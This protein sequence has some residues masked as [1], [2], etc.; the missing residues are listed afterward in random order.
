MVEGRLGQ[1]TWSKIS[2]ASK[3]AAMTSHL[4]TVMLPRVVFWMIVLTAIIFPSLYQPILSQL[5]RFLSSNSL[6]RFSG[7]E[8]LETIFCYIVIEPLYTFRFTQN[9]SL[10]I[11]VRHKTVGR[12]GPDNPKWPVMKRPS[13][14]LMEIVTYA[15][16]LLT[17][18]FTLIKKFADVPV[19]DIRQ[20]GG[21]SRHS[22]GRIGGFFLAPTLHNFSLNS[23][24]QLVRALPSEAPSSRRLA[25]ELIAAFFIYDS[26]FFF[27]HIAFHKLPFLRQIHWPHH[28]HAEMNPQVTNKLSITERV[29]LILLANFALNIIRSHVLT[30]TAFVPCFVYLLVE[31]HSGLDLPWAYDKIL[32]S[33]W[34]AG[35]EKH[36][37]HHRVGEG[38]YQPFFSWWDNLLERWETESSNE[39]KIIIN[40]TG[41]TWSSL[42]IVV[43]IFL[44]FD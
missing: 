22:D 42:S 17:L 41:N 35:S 29:S 3:Q 32:P 10:R 1:P 14:R 24:L 43:R 26:L 28:R 16:P 19:E 36:A 9:P 39:P 34:G 5:W 8:T 4:G 11:D 44:G 23:P 33:G 7:F 30:R 20:S 2:G 6:Y 18:D 12:F 25:I 38:Y 31:V 13:K 27:I 37:H 15:A 40:R 21:Y